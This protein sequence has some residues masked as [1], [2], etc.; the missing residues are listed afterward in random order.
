MFGALLKRS[1]GKKGREVP[2]A[3]LVAQVA[4]EAGVSKPFVKKLLEGDPTTGL[5]KALRVA[6]AVGLRLHSHRRPYHDDA[7]VKAPAVSLEAKRLTLAEE[8]VAGKQAL[9]ATIKSFKR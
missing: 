9:A 6:D 5:A 2:T 7:V 3:R 8:Q 4:R 1:I